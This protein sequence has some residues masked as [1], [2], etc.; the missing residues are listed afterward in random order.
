MPAVLLILHT[1]DRVLT[2]GCA[3]QKASAASCK[4]TPHARRT[5]WKSTGMES[6][7]AGNARRCLAKL[8][9]HHIAVTAAAAAANLAKASPL[10][11]LVHVLM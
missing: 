1:Q 10:K 7:T 11:S 3:H 2:S 6:S 9:V 4:E 8:R 5:M